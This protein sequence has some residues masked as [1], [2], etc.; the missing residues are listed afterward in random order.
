MRECQDLEEAGTRGFGL[1][2]TIR[3]SRGRLGGRLGRGGLAE[4][5][6]EERPRRQWRRIVTGGE[7]G[8]D[9]LGRIRVW[10]GGGQEVDRRHWHAARRE[11]NSIQFMAVG[12]L[13]LAP[14]VL[15]GYSIEE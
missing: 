5:A 2:D 11:W 8:E 15:R 7:F 3:E 10:T 9:V 4:D 1:V 12:V 14:G 13:C 6:V